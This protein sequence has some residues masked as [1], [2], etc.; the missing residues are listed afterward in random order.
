[1][2]EI[3]ATI[4]TLGLAY[5]LLATVQR[6]LGRL[7][8]AVATLQKGLAVTKSPQLRRAL[9][10][11]QS[12]TLTVERHRP[13]FFA[14]GKMNND[15]QRSQSQ[16]YNSSMLQEVITLMK[17][18]GGFLQGTCSTDG[19]VHLARQAEILGRPHT[20]AICDRIQCQGC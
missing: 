19:G 8:E 18:V 9:E 12:S 4:H 15:L 20:I 7:E 1:M 16:P 14:C 6:A 13:T 11:A 17:V 2:K 5:S 3:P 10:A